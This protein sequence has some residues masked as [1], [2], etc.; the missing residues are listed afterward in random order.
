MLY[1]GSL[2][3]KL[4]DRSVRF[5]V[6]ILLE[7]NQ[8]GKRSQGTPP[9]RWGEYWTSLSEEDLYAMNSQSPTNTI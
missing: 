3:I 1:L 5:F 9:K 6:F 4:E 8:I 7:N 2:K